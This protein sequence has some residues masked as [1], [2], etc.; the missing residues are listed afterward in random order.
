M[1]G[2]VTTNQQGLTQMEPFAV[3][4]SDTKDSKGIYIYILYV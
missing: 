2:Y 3:F 4:Q 1:V